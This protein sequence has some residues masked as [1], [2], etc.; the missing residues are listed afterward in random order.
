MATLWFCLTAILI[1]GYV[2]LDGF[3]LGA[4]IVQLF[5]AR[6]EFEKNQVLRSI[7]PVW[8]GNEVWLL[9]VGG[10]LFCAFPVLY[11]S[12]FSGFYLSLMMVLWLLILRG[13][14]IEFRSHADIPLWRPLWDTVFGLASALLA[15]VYGMALG[16]VVRG[17]PLDQSGYFFLPFWTNFRPSGQVGIIDWY[18]LLVGVASFLALTVHGSLWIVWKTAGSLQYRTR[19]FAAKCWSVSVA[20]TLLMT[21]ASFSLQPNLIRQFRSHPWGFLFPA[22]ALVGMIEIRVLSSREKDLQAFFAS[23]L[24]LLGMFTS[25][26]FGVFPNVLPAN[27]APGLSLT[28]QNAAAA[29][30]GL[31]VALWWFLPGMALAIG[32]SILV[33]RHFAGKV[34]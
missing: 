28:I 6:S 26:A 12:A 30:H 7:G 1:A 10:A 17:V 4:G 21:A 31:I 16:N 23:G 25:V 34:D 5:V 13:I 14:S 29:E 33:Y 15:L 24:Y 8:D 20:I 18:T 11:A 27:T 19:S 22:L 3:D 9:A 2:L 32:Y